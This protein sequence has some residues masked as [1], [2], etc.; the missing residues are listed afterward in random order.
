MFTMGRDPER[1]ILGDGSGDTYV[2]H[3]WW[4]YAKAKI[5]AKKLG[6]ALLP[7]PRDADDMEAWEDANRAAMGVLVPLAGCY[8]R[9]IEDAET[10]AEAVAI[11]AAHFEGETESRRDSLEEDF[12][13]FE[14][15]HGESLHDA[16]TRVFDLFR[17]LDKIGHWP[18]RGSEAYTREPMARFTKGLAKSGGQAYIFMRDALY[19]KYPNPTQ[20]QVLRFYQEREKQLLDSERKRSA[21]VPPSGAVAFSG[22]SGAGAASSSGQGGTNGA[23]GRGRGGRG[24][25][26]GP[27][28]AKWPYPNDPRN[29]F[30]DK[31]VLCYD[32]G[33]PGHF[34]D[35]C[36]NE[37]L[38]GPY[39]AWRLQGQGAAAAEAGGCSSACL[40]PSL[41]VPSVPSRSSTSGWWGAAGA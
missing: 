28:Q 19:A 36:S 10:I 8:S 17:Q 22:G 37:H 27:P 3:D 34:K 13:A 4:P 11:L 24:G 14:R 21:G 25:A 30:G 12:L 23:G 16:Y 26:R 9:E 20:L 39:K 15:R 29:Q 32:C 38:W 40:P 1:P 2:Y 5:R 41:T 31:P 33:L 6:V 35:N 7:E 18:D